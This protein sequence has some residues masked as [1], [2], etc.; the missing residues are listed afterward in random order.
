M[1]EPSART[2]NAMHVA[3][4][5]DE[6]SRHYVVYTPRHVSATAASGSRAVT[7]DARRRS[8]KAS[9]QKL[10]SPPYKHALRPV[11]CSANRGCRCWPGAGQHG[12]PIAG[13]WMRG[14]SYDCAT[15]P[16]HG[17]PAQGALQRLPAGPQQ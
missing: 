10:K 7:A 17:R 6:A 13:R 2:S 3:K 14:A 12:R 8:R 15:V 11:L 4:R 1:R 9:S 5:V 16:G